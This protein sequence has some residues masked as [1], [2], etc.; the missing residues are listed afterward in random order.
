MPDLSPLI[1]RAAELRTLTTLL[2]DATARGGGA[3]VIRGEAGVGKS[4]L[5]SR[6]TAAARARGMLVLQ[7]S[8]VQAEG[9]I[10][11]AGLHRLLRPVAATIGPGSPVRL[12]V[13]LLDLLGAA[14]SPVLLAVED[15]PW[16]DTASWDVLTFAGRRLESDR[17]ALVFTARDGTD[18]DR[19]LAG[20]GLPELRVEPLSREDAGT[21]LDRTAPGLPPTLRNRVLDESA[22]N[23]LGLTELG[24][25][26]ARSDAA[27]L[28][29]SWLPSSLPSSQPSSQ[30]SSLPL[31]A[32]VEQLFSALV[33]ELPPVTR[34]LLL[35]AALDDSDDLDEAVAAAAVALRG[36]VKAE[37]IDPAVVTRLVQIDDGYRIAFRHPLLRSA[38]RQSAGAAERRRAH[39]ALAE[40][41]GPESER[42]LWH[43]AAATAGPD[44]EVARRLTDAAWR[45]GE[46]QAVAVALATLERAVQLSEDPAERGERL[47]T[48]VHLTHQQ[49]DAEAARRLLQR[50]DAAELRPPDRA[51]LAWLREFFMGTGWSGSGPLALYAELI[52]DIRESGNQR[53]ALDSLSSICV[54]IHFSNVDEAV[55]RQF[56]AVV[57]ALGF[58]A[59]H[60]EVIAVVGLIAPVERGAACLEIMQRLRHRLD[61]TPTLH[62]ELGLAASSLGAFELAVGFSGASSAGLR[63]QG[64][65]GLL[66]QTLATRTYA[67][68]CLG[69]TRT[70]IL[71]GSEAVALSRDTGRQSWEVTARLAIGMAQALRGDSAAAL[72]AADFGEAVFIPGRMYSMLA[73]VQQVRGLEAL[74]A[75][76]AADACHEL[77]RM[78]DPADQAFHPYVRLGMAGHLAEAAALSGAHDVLRELVAE[79]EPIAVQGR[80]PALRAGLAYARAVLA[81]DEAGYEAALAT[82][83]GNFERARAQLAY[84]SWLR[85]RRQ[86]GRARPHLRGAAAAF[87]ALG[88]T[89][90]A[91]RALA[92]LRVTGETRRRPDDATATLTPQEVQIAR[93]AADG[94]SNREIAG[95]LFLSPRTVSTHLYRIYPKVGVRSRTELA[96]LLLT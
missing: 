2:D 9:Q 47:L 95:R 69:D 89:P 40:V 17:I 90:W 79:L 63:E 44:E 35:V 28:L 22:G 29:P 56:L 23:P 27:A 55:R 94:L 11:Y 80:N 45:A 85:R 36:P 68:A 81:D 18:I 42:Q 87:E 14:E 34:T 19:R 53:L 76:R 59:D 49:G 32:R 24:A 66:A 82:D 8:G 37:D 70:A 26:A 43:L 30:P 54:R 58:P 6:I 50:I 16:L 41:I 93:L 7:V 86:R 65:I 71:A 48:A 39:A 72:E 77:R 46:R 10:A 51:R 88:A 1:G 73:L 83:A 21:L 13:G 62:Y 5:L 20:A 25:A 61:L 91:E 64:R 78:F 4:A 60:P 12:A 96:A 74:A 57:D 15:A 84:G 38:L 92:E 52:D 75:G 67:A 31:S 3:M 33:A